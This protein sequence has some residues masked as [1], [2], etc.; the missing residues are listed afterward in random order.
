VVCPLLTFA[1][2]DG[3]VAGAELGFL[4]EAALEDAARAL[5]AG[6]PLPALGAAPGPRPQRST[7]AA[8]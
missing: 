2:R 4:D 6:R 5:A 8:S 1:G 3:R 7:A